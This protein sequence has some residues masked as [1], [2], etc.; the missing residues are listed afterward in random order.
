MRS[1]YFKT[2][3]ELCMCTCPRWIPLGLLDGR[4]LVGAGK[5]GTEPRFTLLTTEASPQPTPGF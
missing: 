2:G 1:A 4:Q 5:L 3:L